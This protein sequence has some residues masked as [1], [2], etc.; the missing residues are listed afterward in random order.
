MSSGGSRTNDGV[1]PDLSV[2]L[3]NFSCSPL[4]SGPRSRSIRWAPD[5][6]TGCPTFDNDKPRRES[7]A[8]GE[9]QKGPGGVSARVALGSFFLSMATHFAIARQPPK[10][11][12]TPQKLGVPSHAD[13]VFTDFSSSTFPSPCHLSFPTL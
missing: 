3:L 6:K 5:L 1:E 9:A 10:T 11:D 7:G 12:P 13:S 4:R 8:V 2:Q